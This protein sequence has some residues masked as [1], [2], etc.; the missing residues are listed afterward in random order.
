MELMSLTGLMFLKNLEIW[1]IS[2]CNLAGIE[3]GIFLML[4]GVILSNALLLWLGVGMILEISL[5]EIFS[6]RDLVFHL[7]LESPI[8][9]DR[10]KI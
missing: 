1:I 6:L 10:P 9:I 5:A 7:H 4:A 3:G 2:F 8:W